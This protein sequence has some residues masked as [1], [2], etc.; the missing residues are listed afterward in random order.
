MENIDGVEHVFYENDSIDF[1]TVAYK[2][3]DYM[4]VLVRS[5]ENMLII[6]TQFILLIMDLKK[7]LM[8]YQKY[9]KI[10]TE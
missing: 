1:V 5:I 6:H 4:K 2:R 10:T 7:V 8:N 9:L 3:F